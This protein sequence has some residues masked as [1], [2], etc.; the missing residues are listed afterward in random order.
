MKSETPK[1][2]HAILGEPILGWVL[3][4]VAGASWRQ[5]R[6]VIGHGR[7]QVATY[8]SDTHPTVTPV[9]QEQQLG[10]GDAVRCALAADAT[11][12]QA[13]ATAPERQAEPVLVV[14]GDMPLLTSATLDALLAEHV[15]TGATMTMLTAVVADPS[16][17]GRVVRDPAG[18]VRAVVEHRDATD[19]QRQILEINTSIY[20]FARGLLETAL[21]QLSDGNSQGELYLTDV[22]AIADEVGA[23][24]ASVQA[25]DPNE[26]SGIN[27]RAQLAQATRLLSRR[28]NTAYQLAGVTLLDPDTTWIEPG[29]EIAADA[30]IERNT[31]VDAASRIGA[32]AVVGPDTTLIGCD[33]GPG[34]TVLRSHCDHAAI[35]PDCAVGPFTFLRPGARLAAGAKAGAYV[36]IKNSEVGPG[37]KV[38]HLTYVGDATIGSRSNVGAAT[39]FVNYDGV[40][41]HRTTVG[42]EVRIGSDTMLVA[43]VHVGDGAYTAAGSVITEDVPAGAMAIG[44]AR[45]RNIDGWVVAKRAGSGSAAAAAAAAQSAD[46]AQTGDPGTAR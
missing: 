26:V 19:H 11:G 27:D 29:A 10:T 12:S 2:M 1:V 45:Q 20:V 23:K 35:G 18:R 44:R 32:W 14:A 13:E 37:S 28:T 24:I 46:G 36:E 39:V 4:A 3:D 22:V 43:P 8:L 42:D 21:A 30:V 34:A 9:V 16:G 7:D 6:V 5:C 38:P 17:Y 15:S 40:A 31:Y 41:K 33:V 25:D